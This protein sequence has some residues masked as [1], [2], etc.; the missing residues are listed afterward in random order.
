MNFVFISPQFPKTYWNFCDRLRR[1]GVTT[2][3][4]GDTPYDQL[5]ENLKNSLVEYYKVDNMEDYDQVF[6]A[7]AYFSFRYGKIDWLESNNEY[8]LEQDARLRTDFHITTG[9][10]SVGIESFKSK[11]AMKPF[12]KKA[13]VPT[14]RHHHVT[15]KNSALEFID[16]VGYPL[17]AKPNIGVGA[18]D[19]YRIDNIDDFEAFYNGKPNVPYIMEEFITGD[20][21][22]YDAITDNECNIIFETMTCWPPSIMDIVNKGLDLHYY[23]AGV[24]V[25]KKFSQIGRRT[26]K[27]FNVKSR[28]VHMEF[29]R[30]TVA[31]PG[32][33]DVGDFVGLEVNMRPA[34]GYTPDMFNFANS[35]DVYQ[36]WA[37]MVAFN[38]SRQ[39]M[40]QEKFY[41]CYASQRDGHSYVHSHEEILGRYGANMVMCERI[42]EI[43]SA[44]MGN[45][46]YTVKL[47][48]QEEV[49]EFVAFVTD[50]KE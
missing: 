48:T 19:T 9:V 21:C 17:I 23:T 24:P 50:R 34:G 1:N 32:L 6:R 22:S 14:A 45:Q 42:P 27:A 29:F 40:D 30:L 38:E 16:L 41:C 33:G 47:K 3:G 2:L 28:F 36:I 5:D 44:A 25:P 31:K 4:V 12:Y 13:K 18:N 10:D 46:M 8:W 43:L 35:V 11:A 39:N 37:D 7:V 15:D 20:I 49:E 26:V